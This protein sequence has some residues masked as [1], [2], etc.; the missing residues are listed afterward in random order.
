MPNMNGGLKVLLAGE[1]SVTHSIEQ[2]GFSAFTTGRYHEGHGVFQA[3]LESE[4]VDLTYIPNHRAKSEFPWNPEELATFDVILLSDISADTLLLHDDTFVRNERTPNRL[5]SINRFVADGG[6]FAM[7]GG[8]MS[9]SGLGGKACYH[10]SPM[11][12]LLPVGMLGYDDRVETPEGVTPE[13]VLVDHPILEG[14]QTDWPCLLGYNKL[15]ALQRGDL[16][17]RCNEDPLLVVDQVDKGRV[18]AFASDCV[19]HWGS[20]E[21]MQWE[22]YPLF[23]NRLVWWLGSAG[24]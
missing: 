6:G 8:Y 23:W 12:D 21:F 10:L 16:L 24:A 15:R 7:I 20:R 13:V 19:G 5:K 18:A 3:A 17:M 2:W 11:A 1:S 4:G 22:H 14:M 9:F